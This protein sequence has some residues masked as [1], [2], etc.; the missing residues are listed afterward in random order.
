MAK[1]L[2]SAKRNAVDKSSVSGT[3]V[4]GDCANA[5]AVV[6]KRKEQKR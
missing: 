2:S 4:A 3:C 1:L 5:Q 6:S